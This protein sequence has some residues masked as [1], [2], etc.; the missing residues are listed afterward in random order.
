MYGIL[1]LVLFSVVSQSLTRI[2]GLVQD[3]NGQPVPA[4]EVVLRSDAKVSRSIADERGGFQFDVVSPGDYMLDFGKSGFFQLSNY[5][6]NAKPG[7][8]EIIV[9]L[10]HESEIRSEVDVLSEPHDIAP[11]QMAHEEQIVGYEIREDPV[12]SSH[13]LQNALPALPVVV[14]D[15]AGQLHVAGARAEDTLYILDGFEINDPASGGF[16]ARVNVDVVREVDVSTGRYGGQLSRAGAGILALQ[17]DAGDDH[18]RFGIT[19]FLPT[20]STQRGT[21][22]GNWFP[23]M[24]FSGPVRKGRAWF[25]NGASVQHD[26]TLVRE[27]PPGNDVSQSW[28]G[29]DILRT[30]Y[31]LTPSHSLQ[32]DFLYAV[33]T[34]SRAG[35]NAFAPAET[36]RDERAHRYFVA[37]KDQITLHK[38]LIDVAFASDADHFERRPQGSQTFVLTPTGPQGNYFETL[39]QNSRRWHGRTDFMFFERRWAGLHDF[40]FG[41]DVDRTHLDQNADRHS[42][43]VRQSDLLVRQA[44]FLGNGRV[45]E[46]NLQGGGYAQDTWHIRHDVILQ[47]IF[48]FDRNDF[49]GRIQPEPRFILNWMPRAT[50]KF[51]MGW[52]LYY[53][54]VYPSLIAQAHDQQRLDFFGSNPLLTS[55]FVGQALHQPYF[56]M[57]S[58]EWQHQWR[59]HTSFTVHLMR[60]RQHNGLAYENVSADPFRRDLLLNDHRRDLYRS[61]E[62]TVRHSI[63]S[64][65]ELMLAYVYARTR[66]NEV[67]D[68]S[69]DDL[70]VANQSAGQ[71]SWDAPHRIVSRGAF[72]TRFWSLLLSYFTEYHTG[73]PFSAVNSSYEVVGVPNGFRYPSYFALNIGV[74]KRV[75]FLGKQWA[76]R[77]SAINVTGHHNYNAVINNIDAPN[78]LTF[79]GGQSRAFTARLRFV[80][81]I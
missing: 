63:H 54:P 55:F 79:A 40:Q 26:L 41:F 34:S 4:V 72:Q 32:A 69:V 27:L 23:R 8:N 49:I 21:R 33:S 12:A 70:V 74:E 46:S 66:S 29:D 77:L 42:V 13:N 11:Q 50:T 44:T 59:E 18:W 64:G 51:S 5:P 71:L 2:S 22:L 81:R 65:S 38:G 43:E 78:F 35:L 48:R 7:L 52:G 1:T 36:T 60:R 6:I 47:P 3:E 45:S 56:E 80:G 53:Q 73:F 10:N 61:A 9:T 58:V 14:Q 31:N 62:I 19:N 25:S 39:F 28:S 20:L 57:A 75:P 37:V 16:D 68:Y 76:V 17:T 15:N 30:Q 67:F 24:N